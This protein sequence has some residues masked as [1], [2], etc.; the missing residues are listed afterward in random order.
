MQR[1]LTTAPPGVIRDPA[2]WVG[3]EIQK[4]RSWVYHLGNDAIEEIDAALAHAKRAGAGIPFGKDAFP[5]SRVAHE[6]D[7]MLDE[8]ENGRGFVLIR[9]IPRRRYT[10]ADCELLYW[11]LGVHLGTPVSQ[12]AR[13]HPRPPLPG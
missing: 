1:A 11:G 8:V 2:A 6:L 13:G 4:D 12:N 5:L 10:D 9:G 7:G 3:A